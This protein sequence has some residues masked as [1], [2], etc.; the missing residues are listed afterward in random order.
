MA[1]REQRAAALADALGKLRED[2][3]LESLRDTI[4]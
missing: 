3:V 4:C 2:R 1:H